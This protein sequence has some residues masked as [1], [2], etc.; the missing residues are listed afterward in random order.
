[1]EK[2]ILNIRLQNNKKMKNNLNKDPAVF[3]LKDQ[4]GI[5]LSK[6]KDKVKIGKL[7]QDVFLNII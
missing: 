7:L 1:M 6:R 4:I 5:H 3:R 2:R